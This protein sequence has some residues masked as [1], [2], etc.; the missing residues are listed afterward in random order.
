MWAYG[1]RVAFYVGVFL[2]VQR[3]MWVYGVTRGCVCVYG[4]SCGCVVCG[5]WRFTH[6]RARA[7]V[8]TE[9]LE[10]PHTQVHLHTYVRT[11]TH[12]HTH[13]HA[14][15]QVD[16]SLAK[17]GTPNEPD[18]TAPLVGQ[19]DTYRG[20]VCVCVC[21]CGCVGVHACVCVRVRLCPHHHHCHCHQT[22]PQ[23][24]PLE[25]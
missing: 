3:F 17:R 5:V 20:C 22:C 13:P 14:T 2:G 12:T 7:C 25:N 4:V 16:D 19:M 9:V 18:G 10:H 11:Q 6:E 1:G 15:T 8:R 24:R 21:V 23:P